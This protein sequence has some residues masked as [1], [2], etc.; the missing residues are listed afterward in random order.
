MF[1]LPCFL[2]HVAHIYQQISSL[3]YHFRRL[4]AHGFRYKEAIFS[5]LILSPEKALDYPRHKIVGRFLVKINFRACRSFINSTFIP[6][7]MFLLLIN[8][9]STEALKKA[10]KAVFRI[11]FGECTFLNMQGTQLNRINRYL[12]KTLGQC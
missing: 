3:F 7:K 11:D 8:K 12:Q 4:F 9:Q 6:L 1:H 5:R 2:L 10:V